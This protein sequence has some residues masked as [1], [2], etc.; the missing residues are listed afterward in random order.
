MKFLFNNRFL[1]EPAGDSAGG[2]GAGSGAGSAGAGAGAGGSGEGAGAAGGAG[3]AAGAGGAGGGTQERWFD[4]ILKSDPSTEAH[5]AHLAQFAGPKEFI[6]ASKQA[7]TKARE[8]TEG[9]IKLPGEGA[10]PEE[11]AAYRTAIG[12][13]IDH[14]GYGLDATETFKAAGLEWTPE[15]A[16]EYSKAAHDLGLP[17][18]KAGKLVEMHLQLRSAEQ[19]AL[20][21]HEESFMATEKADLTKAFGKDL[22][23]VVLNGQRVGQMLGIDAKKFD[24]G[25]KEFMSFSAVEMLSMT[26]ELAKAKGETNLPAAAAVGALTGPEQ[27]RD[28]AT[29][30]DNPLYKRYQAGDREISAMVDRLYGQA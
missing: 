11:I 23:A 25:A 15:L 4:S 7:H 28:I 17:K 22:N 9:F 29:N 21:K 12:I 5:V 30:P 20:A 24:P 18:D 27:A 8:K 16:E 1:Y 19:A 3:G 13:P 26:R 14:K 10:T 2:G 6:E